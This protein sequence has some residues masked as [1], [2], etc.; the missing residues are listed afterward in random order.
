MYS[1]LTSSKAIWS[2]LVVRGLDSIYEARARAYCQLCTKIFTSS[3]QYWL[4]HTSHRNFKL[5]INGST[6][7]KKRESQYKLTNSVEKRKKKLKT[8]TSFLGRNL[9]SMPASNIQHWHPSSHMN[10][11]PKWC[12]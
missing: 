2:V 11:K 12:N 7:K 8:C 4:W 6:K 10:I 9:Y 1:I 5:K 3:V